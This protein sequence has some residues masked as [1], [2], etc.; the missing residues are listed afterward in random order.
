MKGES[1]LVVLINGLNG[2]AADWTQFTRHA[3]K[4][5]LRTHFLQVSSFSGMSTHWGIE[6]GGG[7]V[8][9]EVIEHLNSASHAI[10]HMSIVGHSLGGLIARY[11]AKLLQ[12]EGVFTRVTPYAFVTMASPHLGVRRPQSNPWNMT[13][14]NV[15]RVLCKSTKELTLYDDDPLLVRM[16]EPAFLSALAL[17]QRRVLYANIFNDFQVPYTT[18]ALRYRNPYRYKFSRHPHYIKTLEIQQELHAA[19]TATAVAAGHIVPNRIKKRAHSA[20]TTG[21]K[22]KDGFF[23]S[24]LT[25]HIRHGQSHSDEETNASTTTQAL[26]Q[27]RMQDD[28]LIHR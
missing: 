27:N 23:F 2:G 19:A 20:G 3:G 6:R 16:T 25:P 21:S 26:S 12:D 13:F 24:H 1:H 7:K 4:L 22:H 10:T 17:F 14:Q 8:A 28:T 15:G 11:L 9:A 18:A 5:G